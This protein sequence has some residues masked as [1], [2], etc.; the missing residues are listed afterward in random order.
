MDKSKLQLGCVSLLTASRI[1]A[2]AVLPLWY[3]RGVSLEE[4]LYCALL[5]MALASTDFLDG[6]LSRRWKCTTELGAILDTVADKCLALSC[7]FALVYVK[8]LPAWVFL[9][10]LLRDLYIDA[11]RMGAL[12][13]KIWVAPNWMGKWKMASQMGALCLLFYQGLSGFVHSLALVLLGFS[14]VL[15]VAS[16]FS[17]TRGY[18]KGLTELA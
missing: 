6:Y 11:L 10:F 14:L 4:S 2:A 17:Y 12:S 16:A 7:L 15:A 3:A 5:L 8:Q 18:L 9:V 1:V 13:K